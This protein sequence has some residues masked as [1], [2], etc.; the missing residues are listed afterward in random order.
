MSRVAVFPC[1]LTTVYCLLLIRAV[2]GPSTSV[3]IFAILVPKGKRRGRKKKPTRTKL[4]TISGNWY[5]VITA[6]WPVA[7]TMLGD[8]RRR[9]VHV[10]NSIAGSQRHRAWRPFLFGRRAGRIRGH[11]QLPER[12][13]SLGE[14]SVHPAVSDRRRS[15]FRFSR[16]VWLIWQGRL[17]RCQH[18]S[19]RL[20]APLILSNSS[21][22]PPSFFPAWNN[23]DCLHFRLRKC[24]PYLFFSKK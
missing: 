24:R 7:V 1:L 22:L 23:R 14:A 8:T 4:E 15:R 13:D 18:Y 19:L 17:G 2:P 11:A 20:A 6:L 10:A 21:Y 12:V 9:L 3:A 5:L 16:V